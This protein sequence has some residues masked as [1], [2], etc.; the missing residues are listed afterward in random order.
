[1]EDRVWA[2]IKELETKKKNFYD[3]FSN[4]EARLIKEWN[5]AIDECI[6]TAKMYV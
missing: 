6:S 2:L 3:C 1:M 4:E 5:K